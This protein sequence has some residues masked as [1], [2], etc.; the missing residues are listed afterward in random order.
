MAAGKLLVLYGINNLGKTTQARRLVARLVDRGITAEYLKYPLYDL[1]PSGSML[2]DYLRGGNPHALS[3]REAQLLYLMNRTHYDAILR[4]RLAQGEWVV[5]EDYVGT[6]IAWGVGAGV[7]RSFLERAGSHLL[8]EDLGIL[9]DGERFLQARESGH[10]HEEDEELMARVRAAHHELAR[11]W[12]WVT[13]NAND[14]IDAI[15]EAVWEIV[16]NRLS[17]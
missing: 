14:S 17:L 16:K 6:G 8:A 2:N 13:I 12:G 10:L 3:A 7:D 1:E 9:F 15:A 11:D 5:A 4:S